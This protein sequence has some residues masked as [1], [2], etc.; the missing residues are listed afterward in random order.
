MFGCGS[1]EGKQFWK[2]HLGTRGKEEGGP[3][4]RPARKRLDEQGD[5]TE[6]FSKSHPDDGLDEDLGRGTRVAAERLD[7]FHADK[8]DADCGGSGDN[9]G[10]DFAPFDGDVCE[11]FHFVSFFGLLHRDA[12]TR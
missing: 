4:Y 11:E 7:S 6:T 10:F 12:H 2:G 3:A 9:G 1:N 5:K 8:T